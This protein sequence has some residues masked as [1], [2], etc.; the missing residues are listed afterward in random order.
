[1]NELSENYD[2]LIYQISETYQQGQVRAIEAVNFSMVK[3]YWEIGQYIIEFEQRGTQRA[4]YGESLLI[5]LS[6]DLNLLHGKGF[7][8]S[9]IQ[10]NETIVCCFSNLCDTVAQIELVNVC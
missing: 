7:S 6:K 5:K 2:G 1:M 4:T 9:N 10:K 8:V 3:T